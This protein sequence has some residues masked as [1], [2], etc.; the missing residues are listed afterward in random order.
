LLS[1]FVIERSAVTDGLS[2]SV[3][4]LF[5]AFGS[6]TPAGEVTVAVFVILPVAFAATVAVTVYVAVAPEGR[7]AVVLIALVPLA[8]PHAPPPVAVQVQV[9]DAMP[10]ASGSAIV[11]PVT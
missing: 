8:A 10:V 1:D 2:T 7:L 11:A 4:V 6:L 9:V 5:A 3:A